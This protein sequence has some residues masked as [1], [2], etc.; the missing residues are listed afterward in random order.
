MCSVSLYIKICRLVIFLH[1]YILPVIY[2]H[3]QKLI[4]TVLDLYSS[5][6]CYQILLYIP[7]DKTSFQLGIF[8]SETVLYQHLN[9]PES[10]R[11]TII[12]D[13]SFSPLTLSF[14]PSLSCYFALWDIP[15]THSFFTLPQSLSIEFIYLVPGLLRQPSR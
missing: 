10:Y 15:V 11:N 5:T 9:S 1:V 14:S 2:P 4:Y 7:L 12:F 13:Y 6:L 3:F 8:F